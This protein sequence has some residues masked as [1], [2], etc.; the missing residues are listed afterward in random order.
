MRL[1][2]ETYKGIE[3]EFD[4]S[5]QD[6]TFSGSALGTISSYRYQHIG[7]NTLSEARED[8]KTKVDKFLQSTP[9]S[10]TELTERITNT[11]VWTGY[12]DCHADETIIR[13][14]VGNFIKYNNKDD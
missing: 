11:L 3:L 10:Y 5:G 8:L 9:T 12:E 1:K 7:W 13:V 14:L 4:V 6:G 2:I